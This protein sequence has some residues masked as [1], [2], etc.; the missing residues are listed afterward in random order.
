MPEPDVDP[1]DDDELDAEPEDEPEPEPEPET[2]AQRLERLQGLAAMLPELELHTD[3]MPL[4]HKYNVETQLEDAYRRSARLPSGG[5][6]V[7]DQTE[8][9]VAVDV[10]SGRLTDEADPESTALVTNLEAV[11]ETARQLRLRDL[12]GLV[13]ID[14]IDMRS[15]S[16]RRQV[17]KALKEA[18]SADRARIRMGRMDPFGLVTLS[19]QRIR[20]ALTRVTHEACEPCGGTGRRRQVSGL[21]LRVVREMEARVARSRGRGGLEVRAPAEVIAWIKKNRNA[22][23]KQLKRDCTG[24]VKLE[25]DDR[26]A[27]DGWAMKGLPPAGGSE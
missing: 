19:R 21:G 3:R 24:P 14:F 6:I 12:G 8:A 18:L 2:P 15:R 22:A 16:S 20:Q 11:A 25:S 7:I 10:N 17:E 27:A 5:S 23:L 1:V 13:V 9:L 4:F 26:L